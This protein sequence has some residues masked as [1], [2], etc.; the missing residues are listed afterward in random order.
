M[1]A[2][3]EFDAM[4]RARRARVPVPRPISQNRH[5]IAMGLFHGSELSKTSSLAQP[6]KMLRRV[7][8]ELRRLFRD[9][10][11]VHGDLSEYNILV[12]ESGQ[13]TFIDWPQSV[14]RTD[15]R[16]QGLL[17]RDVSNIIR[18]FA[19]RYGVFVPGQEAV[20]F[21]QAKKRTLNPIRQGGSRSQ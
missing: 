7:L 15:P 8:L 17:M 12:A 19:K 13:F 2:T 20:E 11:L 1:A 21:V 4:V 16:A 14:A 5:L 3:R 18:F 9:A 6:G 10:H